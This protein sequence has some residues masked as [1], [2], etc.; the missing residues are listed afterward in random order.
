LEVPQLHSLLFVTGEVDQPAVF[1]IFDLQSKQFKTVEGQCGTETTGWDIG[2][3][4]KN[5]EPFTDWIQD[6]T[7]SS[8]TL[9]H[10]TLNGQNTSI[11]DLNSLRVR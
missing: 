3:P 10:Q 9:V 5:G 7:P 4:R 11:I 8:L 6:T 1:H 2:A